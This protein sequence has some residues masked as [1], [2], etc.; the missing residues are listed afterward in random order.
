MKKSYATVL[1]EE[2]RLVMLRILSELP[3]YRANSST[4][5]TLLAQWGH[6]PSRDQVKGELRWLQEQQLVEVEDIAG[7]DVLIAT[8]SGRGQD[9]ATGRAIVD[10]VQRPG[11]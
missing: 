4:L 1:S 11:A 5:Y 9:V 6:H 10:G 3:Q 7:G 2:R 8:L